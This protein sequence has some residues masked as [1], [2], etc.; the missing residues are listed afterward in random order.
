[1][2]YTFRQRLGAEFLGTAFLLAAVVGSGIMAE[3]LADGNVALA[4]LCNTL[5]TGAILVV[6]ITM[7]G[8]ISGA[9]FNPAVTAAFLIRGE[10][11]LRGAAGYLAMQILGGLAGVIA[12]H[13]MFDETVLQVAEKARTGPSQ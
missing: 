13:L 11:D 5:P 9:H 7:L 8:P 6:I 12:A 2:P 4:L 10:L 1:M 3:R